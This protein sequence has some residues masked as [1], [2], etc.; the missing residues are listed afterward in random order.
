MKTHTNT[1]ATPHRTHLVTRTLLAALAVGTTVWALFPTPPAGTQNASAEGQTVTVA[2]EAPGYAIEDFNY[3]GADRIL[4]EQGI[5]LKRG[6]GHITLTDCT[7]GT[8]LIQIMA[9]RQ[10]NPICFRTTG[11]TG[12]LTLEIPA[13]YIVKGN[14]YTTQVDMTVGGQEK[15]FDIEKNTWTAV[16]ES[17]DDQGREYMLMEIKTTR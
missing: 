10:T 14:D 8:G 16:G 2:G 4:R 12:W 3:P 9:R 15:T 6:D 5:T 1:A 17:A 13:V 7:T 11:T